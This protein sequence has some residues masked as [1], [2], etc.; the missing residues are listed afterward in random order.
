M[1]AHLSVDH[2]EAG[3]RVLSGDWYDARLFGRW[4]ANHFDRERLAALISGDPA[5]G[6]GADLFSHP[7]NVDT[8]DGIFRSA[9][10]AGLTPGVSAREVTAAAFLRSD[11]GR[12]SVLDAFWSLKDRVYRELIHS[13]LG[14][15]ADNMAERRVSSA[16]GDMKESAVRATDVGWH[17][18]WPALFDALQRRE[19]VVP[20][21]DVEY[22][23]RQYLTNNSTDVLVRYTVEKQKKRYSAEWLQAW[24][25]GDPPE[26]T[27][28]RGLAGHDMAGMAAH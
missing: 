7:V 27:Q 1:R 2:H 24:L 16:A 17:K 9:A 12:F 5:G 22:V 8:I 14:V 23:A 21:S 13:P 26:K 10:L 19:M 25:D 18:H 4:L 11:D 6:E 3:L 20:G 15:M 28:G